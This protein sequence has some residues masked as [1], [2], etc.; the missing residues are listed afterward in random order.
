MDDITRKRPTIKIKDI[1][2]GELIDFSTRIDSARFVGAY[3]GRVV[4][5]MTQPQATVFAIE[6]GEYIFVF[7]D[8]ER[9]I[10][11]RSPSRVVLAP[12][13][14]YLIEVVSRSGEE[15]TPFYTYYEAARFVGLFIGHIQEEEKRERK[16]IAAMVFLVGG[17]EYTIE[18][19]GRGR[20]VGMV[21][22]YRTKFKYTSEI[23]IKG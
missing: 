14:R 22:K 9:P 13:S 23:R 6:G 5:E 12:I 19:G 21:C 8:E 4:F 20:K 15:R 18:F 17:G 11:S 10:R 2:S 1:N 7:N 16:G 3:D